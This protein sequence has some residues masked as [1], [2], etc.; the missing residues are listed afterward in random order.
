WKI[1]AQNAPKSWR[2][3]ICTTFVIAGLD[4]AIQRSDR[5]RV[6][7]ALAGSSPAMTNRSV[8]SFTEFEAAPYPPGS[9]NAEI[10]LDLLLDIIDSIQIIC[11]RT[12]L[13]SAN[14]EP[15]GSAHSTPTRYQ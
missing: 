13:K 7:S 6:A 4:P 8:F 2:H 14:G 9:I 10:T 1:P 11:I 3:V 15:L 12:K 5:L